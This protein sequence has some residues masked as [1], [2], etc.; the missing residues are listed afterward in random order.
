M[1]FQLF[2]H[3]KEALEKSENKEGFLYA[4]EMGLGKSCTTLTD[5]IRNN[6]QFLFV[7]APVG[8]AQAWVVDHAPK[9]ASGYFKT[10]VYIQ[11]GKLYN[12]DGTRRQDPLEAP[13]LL[14]VNFESIRGPRFDSFLHLAKNCGGEGMIVVDESHRIKS[15]KAIVTKS[16]LKL[17]PYFQFRRALT[18]TPIGNGHQDLYSQ[19]KFVADKEFP[20]RFF[21][22]F[23]HEFCSFGGFKDKQIIGDKSAEKLRALMDPYTHIAKKEDCLDLPPKI[24]NRLYL[25]LPK[26]VAK[27]YKQAKDKILDLPSGKDM[28]MAITAMHTMRGITSGFL[29]ETPLYDNPNDNPKINTTK[30]LLEDHR[31]DKAII[32]V[33]YINE[34][35]MLSEALK[36][37]FYCGTISQSDRNTL[38]DDFKNNKQQHLIATIQTLGTG[39]DLHMVN[40]EIFYSN[41]YSYLLRTQA[42]DRCHRIGQIQSV[43]VYDLIM[44][45]TI[46]SKIL[47][48]LENK[49]D[50]AQEILKKGIAEFL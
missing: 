17:A 14:S 46:D 49:G 22:H 6:I 24:Y 35:K 9:Y 47:K 2:A 27:L 37:P 30:T 20:Y 16:I 8:V 36:I 12:S 48:V 28:T 23:T 1:S 42:E 11:S 15:P 5:A 50:V 31:R 26:D 3:Q 38:L 39:H 21:S 32:F 44:Q 10:S 33:S 34:G 41:D 7:V 18:G 4:H 43:M 19:L 40:V 13:L 25:D 29:E 45:K